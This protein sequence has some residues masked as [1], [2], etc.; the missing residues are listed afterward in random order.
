VTPVDLV[1]ALAGGDNHPR[2]SPQPRMTTDDTLWLQA[3]DY[4]R[5]AD[6]SR[7]ELAVTVEAT[8]DRA[9]HRHPRINADRLLSIGVS[10][11]AC[12]RT[13]VDPIIVDWMRRQR[14]S[15]R[16]DI[17]SLVLQGRWCASTSIAP[18]AVEGMLEALR[19]LLASEAEAASEAEGY[20]SSR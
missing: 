20:A 9:E 12:R 2:R 1:P 13:D 16:V 8:L 7:D 15:A 14:S 4:K 17:A 3:R 6:A 10:L 19:S 18:A 5:I 11:R